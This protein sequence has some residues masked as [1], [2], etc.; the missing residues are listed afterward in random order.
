MS[1]LDFAGKKSCFQPLQAM[2]WVQ[3]P[4]SAL[5]F[6]LHSTVEEIA[7]WED[8]QYV[9]KAFD[10]KRSIKS[11]RSKAFNQK[12]SIKSVRSKAIDQKRS[13]KSVRSKALDQKHSIKS[14]Q[15]K[16]FDQKHSIK[17]D[18]SKHWC[19][20]DIGCPHNWHFL[21]LCTL[22]NR[23]KGLPPSRRCQDLQF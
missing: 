10:L 20:I 8:I 1:R 2:W 9:S 18:L 15:L 7:S 22:K 12:R 4:K 21:P 6:L 17:S 3:N 16:A 19:S 5:A 23:P 13:I 14:V 11:L